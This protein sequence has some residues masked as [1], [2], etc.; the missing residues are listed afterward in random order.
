MAGFATGSAIR[1]SCVLTQAHTSGAIPMRF[2]LSG[3]AYAYGLITSGTTAAIDH[4]PGSGS[5]LPTWMLCFQPGVKPA[6]GRA[7]G[8]RSFDG[9]SATSFPAVPI[10]DDLKSRIGAVE[11]LKPQPTDDSR[12]LMDGHHPQMASPSA[13][14]RC[15]RRRQTRTVA[16]QGR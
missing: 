2:G 8:M 7:L 10:P 5:R 6:C 11:L 12:I 9:A 16:A 14:C 3:A 1:R 13:I 4:F 15:F